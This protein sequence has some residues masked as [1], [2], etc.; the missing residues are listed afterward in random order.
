MGKFAICNLYDKSIGACQS[1]HGRQNLPTTEARWQRVTRSDKAPVKY[2][3]RI[4]LFLESFIP[5][6]S[7]LV[8]IRDDKV[9]S[10]LSLSAYHHLIYSTMNLL[11]ET[12][13]DPK[14]ILRRG[15]TIL[16]WDGSMEE[17]SALHDLAF[18]EGFPPSLMSSQEYSIIHLLDGI[19]LLD[20]N[21]YRD[22]N[23]PQISTRFCI[24]EN[25]L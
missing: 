17:G 25:L 20:W 1:P 24:I 3:S 12:T 6:T 9:G 21:S 10:H 8:I 19:H 15:S 11:M 5:P 2:L 7:S 18:L 23:S 22:S 13:R 4:Q 14:A 16:Q